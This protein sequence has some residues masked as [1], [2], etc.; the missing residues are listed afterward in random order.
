MCV[1]N[2]FLVQIPCTSNRFLYM[3]EYSHLSFVVC[4]ST[5]IRLSS[6]S[7][8][9]Y[10]YYFQYVL[11]TMYLS[12]FRSGFKHYTLIHYTA[13]TSTVVY[14]ILQYTYCT[15][16]TVYTLLYS[17]L[18]T[19]TWKHIGSRYQNHID[20][21]FSIIIIII[22]NTRAGTG[23]GARA[24]YELALIFTIGAPPDL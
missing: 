2:R 24:K 13:C 11:K 4:S 10:Y 20:L 15:Y 12:L 18:C 23:A 1:A 17:F 9:S 14:I 6:T 19:C 22:I 21:E 5:S 3:Y 16:G 8:G 7:T